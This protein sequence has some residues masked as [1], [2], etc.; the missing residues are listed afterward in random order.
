VAFPHGN[1]FHNLGVACVADRLHHFYFGLSPKTK[2]QTVANVRILLQHLA[3]CVV[4]KRGVNRIVQRVA[5]ELR[6]SYNAIRQQES[7]AEFGHDVR[8]VSG[9]QQYG[10]DARLGL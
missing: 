5:M 8:P 10:M 2:A 7:Y 1:V 4:C 9:Q 6:T 3:H